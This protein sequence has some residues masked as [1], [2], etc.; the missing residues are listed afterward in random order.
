M[1]FPASKLL[2]LPRELREQIWVL[3]MLD[4]PDAFLL[5][6]GM[7]PSQFFYP[8]S[9]P[10]IAFVAPCLFDE[11]F[12]VWLRSRT[13]KLHF[14][15]TIPASFMAYMDTFGA[16]TSIKSMSFTAA[17]RSYQAPPSSASP[18]HFPADLVSLATTLQ[19]LTITISSLFVTHFDTRT[20]YFTHIKPI[21]EVLEVL[22]FSNV[23]RCERLKTLVVYCC[24]T[25]SGDYCL[26]AD[27]LNCRPHDVFVPLCRWFLGKFEQMGKKVIVRGKLD[28]RGKKWAEGSGWDWTA[29]G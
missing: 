17:L 1:P 8:R 4:E 26:E 16:W 5:K 13:L 10:P 12:L 25:W 24:P 3:V 7:E 14:N 21:D 20:G 29:R 27:D 18:T 9:L 28:R 6:P 15:T 11:V 22:D 23:L 19:H 2:C